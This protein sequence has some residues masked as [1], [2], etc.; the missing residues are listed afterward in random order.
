MTKDGKH[1]NKKI[2][3]IILSLKNSIYL[4]KVK[5]KKNIKAV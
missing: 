5:I 4:A 2:K 1:K 3:L